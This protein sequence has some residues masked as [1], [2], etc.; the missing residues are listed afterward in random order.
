MEYQNNTLFNI[1]TNQLVLKNAIFPDFFEIETTGTDDFL[2]PKC[3]SNQLIKMAGYDDLINPEWRFEETIYH[4]GVSA[5]ADFLSIGSFVVNE[6]MRKDGISQID[7]KTLKNHRNFNIL[8]KKITDFLGHYSIQDGMQ[9]NEHEDNGLKIHIHKL[10][11]DSLKMHDMLTFVLDY[12]EELKSNRNMKLPHKPLFRKPGVEVK[13]MLN[14][15]ESKVSIMPRISTTGINVLYTFK[16][17]FDLIDYQFVL[18]LGNTQEYDIGICPYCN[19][20]FSKTS[21]DKIYCKPEHSNAA[22]LRDNQLKPDYALVKYCKLDEC[23][24]PFTPKHQ[25]KEYCDPKCKK[26]AEYLKAKEK[27]KSEYEW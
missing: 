11:Y 21:R 27:R 3:T 1:Q 24:K 14:S 19:T 25:R 8:I 13:L 4:Q 20:F 2:V 12:R 5:L 15:F 10:V 6:I 17:L 16:S 22:R 7:Y 23:G 18:F 26:R 9:S